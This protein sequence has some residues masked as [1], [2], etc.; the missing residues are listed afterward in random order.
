MR[1][2]RLAAVLVLLVGPVTGGCG[3]TDA[4]RP[5]E[6]T[7]ITVT[8]RGARDG[9]VTVSLRCD[10]GPGC[11]A[12]R[13]D[14]LQRVVAGDADRTRVCTQVYGGPERARVTGTLRGRSVEVEVTR[15]DGCGIADYA[16]LFSA[17]GRDAP[18]AP[19]SS[20]SGAGAPNDGR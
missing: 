6:G 1:P 13:L 18:L 10:A 12:G 11:D 5:A 9:P 14:R 19:G 4:G 17:L 3:G 15:E 16:A 7:A 20:P 2:G 8:V